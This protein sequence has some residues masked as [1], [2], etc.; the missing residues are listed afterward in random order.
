MTMEFRQDSPVKSKFTKGGALQRSKS[1]SA[2]G[3]AQGKRSRGGNGGGNI[4]ESLGMGMGAAPGRDGSGR[5]SVSVSNPLARKRS[6]QQIRQ[7]EDAFDNEPWGDTDDEDG[8]DGDYQPD[9]VD[10]IVVLSDGDGDDVGE[11]MET[12]VDT[13][14]EMEPRKRRKSGDGNGGVKVKAGKGMMTGRKEVVGT[15]KLARRRMIGST[16]SGAGSGSQALMQTQMQMQ[17]QVGGGQGRKGKGR[18]RLGG[19]GEDV[20]MLDDGDED[21]WEDDEV[22]VQVIGVNARQMSKSPV[23]AC[24]HAMKGVI[25]KV[26][27]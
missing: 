16:G 21:D 3:G 6:L 17:T 15:S 10:P 4:A 24:F 5:M 11:G 8:E 2:L 14:E 12:E 20:E 26:S 23:D 19:G 18:A 7:E 25:K 22:D 1:T 9:G 27:A 13:D